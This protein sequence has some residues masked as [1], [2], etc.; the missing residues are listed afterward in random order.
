MESY[1]SEYPKPQWL[2]F[3]LKQA[4]YQGT[5]NIDDLDPYLLIY[6]K[7][8][9]Y[10]QKNESIHRLNLARQCFYLKI[11]GGSSRQLDYSAR[12][13]R[14]SYMQNIAVQWN[15]PADLLSS[16]HKQKVLGYKQGNSRAYYCPYTIK[17]LSTDDFKAG[18]PIC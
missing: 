18:R 2:C 15:W 7:V 17:T 8:E 4:I 14:E 13:F 12:V 16:L 6:A 10:L 11:M 1:A 5:I 3:D 9:H